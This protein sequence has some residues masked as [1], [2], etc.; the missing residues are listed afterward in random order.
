MLVLFGFI[1]FGINIIG[2]VFFDHV[3]VLRM[4]APLIVGI[5]SA[6]GFFPGAVI[7]LSRDK[8]GFFELI[9]GVIGYWLYSFHL[10]PL[11]FITVYQ[12]LTRKE[13]T[14]AKTV[15]TGDDEADEV[16][17]EDIPIGEIEGK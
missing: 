1:V 17:N 12:M 3:T 6:F 5:L 9:Y 10:I 14:W 16:V 13:R 8:V 11:F 15:H 4:D 7:T 2:W